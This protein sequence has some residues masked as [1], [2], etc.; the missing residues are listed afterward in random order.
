M[1]DDHVHLS[2][3]RNELLLALQTLLKTGI[4]GNK[5]FQK[6]KDHTTAALVDLELLL[7]LHRV[8]HRASDKL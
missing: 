2:R 1:M 7:H 6:A 3:T 4:M 8:H 5:D